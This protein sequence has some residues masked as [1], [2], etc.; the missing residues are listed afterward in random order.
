M[1]SHL[2]VRACVCVCGCV[3]IRAG[4]AD[5]S[6]EG[7]DDDNEESN[8]D[9]DDSSDDT[10]V[11]DTYFTSSSVWRSYTTRRQAKGMKEGESR[12]VWEMKSQCVEELHHTQGLTGK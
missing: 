5:S 2:C 10:F 8:E 3:C 12:G 9:D 1:L 6:G 11:K 4:Q 7:E